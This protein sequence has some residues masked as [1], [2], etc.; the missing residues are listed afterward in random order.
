MGK[1]TLSVRKLS[2]LYD[3]RDVGHYLV[4]IDDTFYRIC[5]KSAGFFHVRNIGTY[6]VPTR[7][8]SCQ[9]TLESAITSAMRYHKGA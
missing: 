9:D 1:H 7:I 3:S 2:A 8:L 5:H 4:S 6:A